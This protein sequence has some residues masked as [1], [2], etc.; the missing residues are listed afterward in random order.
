MLPGSV[1]MSALCNLFICLEIMQ[2]EIH[3]FMLPL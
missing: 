3:N 1:V 2:L